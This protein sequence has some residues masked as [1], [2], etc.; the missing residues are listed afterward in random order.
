MR[1]PKGWLELW[2][3][4]ANLPHVTP[5][6]SEQVF[7]VLHAVLHVLDGAH[8]QCEGLAR[9]WNGLAVTDK[10]RLRAGPL[11]LARLFHDPSCRRNRLATLSSRNIER[12]L[13]TCVSMRC[14]MSSSTA[15]ASRMRSAEHKS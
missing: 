7:L 15:T 13:V 12:F 2:C 5:V 6:I 14:R 8:E 1:R 3:L 4:L 11:E 10:H 9:Q